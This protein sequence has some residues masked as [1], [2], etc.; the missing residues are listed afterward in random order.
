MFDMI[1]LRSLIHQKTFDDI[2]LLDELNHLV[3]LNYLSFSPTTS[4]YQLQ[5]NSMFY[6]LQ[7]L[8]NGFQ[9]IFKHQIV[10]NTF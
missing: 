4:D 8:W 6:G 5:G 10:V 3:Q 7:N 9:K 1:D 2:M